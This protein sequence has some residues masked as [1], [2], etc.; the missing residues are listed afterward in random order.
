[1]AWWGFE[2]GWARVAHED[3]SIE[4]LEISILDG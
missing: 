2:E 1:M 4:A 3:P